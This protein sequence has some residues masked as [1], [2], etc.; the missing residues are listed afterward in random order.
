MSDKMAVPAGVFFT[1]VDKFVQ[2]ADNDGSQ[3]TVGFWLK[4]S[5]RDGAAR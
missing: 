5:P 4:T 2:H 1:A 3:E